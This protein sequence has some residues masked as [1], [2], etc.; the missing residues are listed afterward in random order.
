VTDWNT[1]PEQ[2]GEFDRAIRFLS[3]VMETSGHNPKPVVLHSVRTGLYLRSIGYS[4]EIVLAGFLHD[5]LED[6]DTKPGEV[7]KR[8]GRKVG[9]LVEA[10]SDDPTIRD[11]RERFRETVRRLMAA[12]PPA[13]IVSAADRLDNLPFF[14]LTKGD[15]ALRAYLLEKMRYFLDVSKPLIGKERL[16]KELEAGY[17]RLP[18]RPP[19]A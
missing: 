17:R 2:D 11:R 9:A 3:S 5:V 14:R 10:L 19:G 18:K 7:T 16:W 1:D 6:S 12:G 8:F 13:L 15:R 4:R